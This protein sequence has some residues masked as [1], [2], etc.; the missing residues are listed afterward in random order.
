MYSQTRPGIHRTLVTQINKSQWKVVFGLF[1]SYNSF[2]TPEHFS[3]LGSHYLKKREKEREWR[4]RG[5]NSPRETSR[6]LGFQLLDYSCGCRRWKNSEEFTS[7]MNHGNNTGT[8][9][10]SLEQIGSILQIL[11]GSSTVFLGGTLKLF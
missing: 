2:Y 10:R 6:M 4:C 8:Q 11:S 3:W 7:Y 9:G 5:I 1:L